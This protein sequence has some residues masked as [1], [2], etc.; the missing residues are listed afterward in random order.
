[1]RVGL[2]VFQMTL[3]IA[4]TAHPMASTVNEAAATRII[5][6]RFSFGAVVLL[7]T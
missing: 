6:A 3:N 4:R 7:F 1:M 2:Y 5:G